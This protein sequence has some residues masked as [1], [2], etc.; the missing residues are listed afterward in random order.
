M[1]FF[2]KKVSLLRRFG[3]ERLRGVMVAHAGAGKPRNVG[4]ADLLPL[5]QRAA[6]R[7]RLP[8]PPPPQQH[9]LPG[10]Q[11]RRKQG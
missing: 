7:A 3:R 5:G 4:A 6:R 2:Y 8:R 9:R 11:P 10:A 1:I